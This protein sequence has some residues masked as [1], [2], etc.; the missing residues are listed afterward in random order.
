[1][2]EQEYFNAKKILSNNGL[3]STTKIIYI[4]GYNTHAIAL[5]LKVLY[6]ADR[7]VVL[8]TPQ[9]LLQTLASVPKDQTQ[10]PE[11][12]DVTFY[13]VED[14]GGED[15]NIGMF[16]SGSTKHSRLYG[17]SRSQIDKT[18]SWYE[19][20]YGVTKDTLIL[21][22]LPPA[23]SFTYIAG[24]LN[25]YNHGATYLYTSDRYT[26]ETI[27][28]CKESYDRIILLANPVILDRLSSAQY[29]VSAS[30]KVLI[31]SGGASL[32]TQA[33]RHFRNRGFNLREGYGLAETCSLST[34]D[35][36]GTDQS[37]G[38]VGV[39]L[40]GVSI[41]LN[42]IGDNQLIEI[43]AEN[44]GLPISVHG[45]KLSILE[46]VYQTTDIGRIEDG[47]LT[48]LGRYTDHSIHG[49]YPKDSLEF[50][51]N[52][53]GA[54]CALI[55]HPGND[56]VVVQLYDSSLLKLDYQIKQH[57]AK[58]LDIPIDKVTVTTEKTLLKSMKQIR[59]IYKEADQYETQ[60]FL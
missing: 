57:L 59:K 47:R 30:A 49:F 44:I 60:L 2:N 3:C 8:I 16:T 11:F 6:D 26:Y 34:F 10:L 13:L 5:C 14:F 56:Q 58:N 21:S 36:E 42:K 31:D 50:I 12:P 53:I 27:D 35:I 29:D 39:P 25:A 4:L 24:I 32:S 40:D 9:D 38:T 20:L 43:S 52:I 15:W 48:I 17:F 55:Q 23:Y 22:P 54:K 33:I 7:K 51:S 45:V 19:K 41:N 37:I 28:R 1:M 18:L 46:T